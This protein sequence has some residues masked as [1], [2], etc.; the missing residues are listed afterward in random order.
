MKNFQF[1]ATLF[2]MYGSEE[3]KRSVLKP[4]VL[5]ALEKDCMDPLG[6]KN[7]CPL[8]EQHILTYED[9]KNSDC[10]THKYMHE[11]HDC[12]RFDQSA[13]N[14]ILGSLNNFKTEMYTHVGG[15]EKW[16]KKEGHY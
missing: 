2:L 12:H 7:L 11:Y 6:S 13:L 8:L 9:C 15:D 4:W 14:I 5:C 16:Y 10:S 3:V 1:G